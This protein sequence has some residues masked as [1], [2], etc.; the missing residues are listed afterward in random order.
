MAKT[1]REHHRIL[2]GVV[3]ASA[4]EVGRILL[5]SWKRSAQKPVVQRTARS[6]PFS[7]GSATGLV[8]ILGATSKGRLPTLQ[9]GRKLRNLAKGVN[10]TAS[11]VDASEEGKGITKASQHHNAEQMRLERGGWV[12]RRRGEGHSSV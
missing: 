12:G 4:S 2:H 11:P 9:P 3:P 6:L 10:E 5:S 8:L 7:T 1:R